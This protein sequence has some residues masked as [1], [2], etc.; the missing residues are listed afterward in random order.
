[1]N[2]EQRERNRINIHHGE[3]E[4]ATNTETRKTNKRAHA[5]ERLTEGA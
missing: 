2:K 4:D 3:R 5:V 1:M